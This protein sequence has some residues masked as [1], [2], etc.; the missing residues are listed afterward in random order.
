MDSSRDRGKTFSFK[1]GAGEV[2]KGWEE[3][4]AR[5]CLLIC[6]KLLEFIVIF[7]ECAQMSK[8]E[9]ANLKISSDLGYGP[10]GIPGTIP[11]DATLCFDVELI[12]FK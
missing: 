7:L 4:I 10:K 2:I 11:P 5:V 9:R 12:S 3:G 1:L 8:G 6:R